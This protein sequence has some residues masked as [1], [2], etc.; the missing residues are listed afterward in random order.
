MAKHAAAFVSELF[1]PS[2]RK[3]GDPHE[4]FII[5]HLFELPDLSKVGESMVH[6]LARYGVKLD[7]P[8]VQTCCG[9]R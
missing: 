7:F 3:M 2:D 4:S 5:Y 6:L 1:M 9:L 8:K